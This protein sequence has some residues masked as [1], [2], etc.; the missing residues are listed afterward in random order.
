MKEGIKMSFWK[1]VGTIGFEILKEVNNASEEHK[2]QE[3]LKKEQEE[4]ELN[5]MKR[6]SELL[7]KEL[8]AEVNKQ[9]V[10]FVYTIEELQAM[11][12]R[13][14]KKEVYA[15]ASENVGYFSE[16]YE[17]SKQ[18]RNLYNETVHSEIRYRARLIKF[19]YE[20]GKL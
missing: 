11:S 4:R 15:I 19:L 18:A 20:N 7:A 13:E 10:T 8:M 5:R 16:R 6:E 12:T 17:I 1:Q 2:K 3:R 14:L 9:E